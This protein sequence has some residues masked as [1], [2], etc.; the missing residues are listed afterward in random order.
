MKSLK[1]TAKK[2]GLWLRDVPGRLPTLL[3]MLW[4]RWIRRVKI[5]RL[6]RTRALIEKTGIYPLNDHFYEPRVRRAG[7]DRSWTAERSLPGIEIDLDAQ[8]AL[9]ESFDVQDEL[10]SFASETA[11]PDRYCPKN[12]YFGPGDADFYYSLI[13]KQKPRRIVEIGSGFSTRIAC[14]ARDANRKEDPGCET[15]ITCIEPYSNAEMLERLDVELIQTPVESVDLETFS[16][17]EPRDILF[18]D[19]SHVVRPEGDVTYEIQQILPRLASG[20]WIHVHD[21]FTPRDYPPRWLVDRMLFWNEQYLLEAFL[22]F[23]REFR[24]A[25]ALNFLSSQDPGRFRRAM[26]LAR[27]APEAECSSFWIVRS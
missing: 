8:W 2:M 13:R 27:L 21:V 18:I 4:L 20:V 25:A 22:A 17:L 1:R 26:P 23:N 12:D 15:R 5:D 11:D 6:P 19:S 24:I 7:L 3:S 16:T 9:L 10:D 14:A